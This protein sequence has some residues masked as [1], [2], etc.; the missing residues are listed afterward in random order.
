MNAI[1]TKTVSKRD[2]Q[3]AVK[4]LRAIKAA[5]NA[6]KNLQSIVMRWMNENMDASTDGKH[7]TI[8]GA[9]VT[10]TQATTTQVVDMD[11]VKAFYA[12]QGKPL[13][14]KTQARS[15]SIRV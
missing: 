14:M 9:N 8:D 11:A 7:F 1:K 13:P 5:E 15:A 4:K 6:K 12:E 3:M 2:A 10:F